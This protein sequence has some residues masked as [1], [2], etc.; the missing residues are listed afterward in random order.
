MLPFEFCTVCSGSQSSLFVIPLRSSVLVKQVCCGV[1]SA[2]WLSSSDGGKSSQ[3]LLHNCGRTQPD[4][5]HGGF[6]RRGMQILH[7]QTWHGTSAQQREISK[8][9]EHQGSFLLP[10]MAPCWD[11]VLDQQICPNIHPLQLKISRYLMLPKDGKNKKMDSN[12]SRLG[13]IQ[14][15]IFS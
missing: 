5:P 10:V 7:V 8:A 12:A 14:L 11:S 3:V 15:A 9:A 2:A 4:L 13:W 6:G 1:C